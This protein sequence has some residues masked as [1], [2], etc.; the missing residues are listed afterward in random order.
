MKK[1]CFSEKYGLHDAVLA[2]RKTQTRRLIPQSILD[3]IEVLRHKYYEA[4]FDRLDGIE[5]LEHYFN[6]ESIGKLPFKVGDVV[7]IAERYKDAN[8]HFIP[9]EDDEFGCYSSP[10]EQTKG[11]DNKMFVRADLMPHRI[12]IKRVWFEH[13]QDISDA[14]CIAEGIEFSHEAQSFYVNY[15][16]TNGTHIWLG[17]SP[18]E[19]YA[20]LINHISGKNT[21]QDNPYVIAYEF[22]LVR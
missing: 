6:A 20:S 10:A 7:A 14:D 19:A 11:W 18:R 1:M 17:D 5:L 15:N 12:R 4:T 9:E 3:K 2:G 22:E 21:W 13:L 16:P 8:I